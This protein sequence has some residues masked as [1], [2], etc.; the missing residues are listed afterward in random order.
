MSEKVV[1]LGTRG[2]ALALAQSG[3]VARMLENAAASQGLGWR[4]ELVTVQTQGD[5]SRAALSQLGGIGVF[6]AQLRTHL[7]EGQVDLA[8]HSF[9][10]L[11]TAP[12]AGLRIAATPRRADPRDALVASNGMSLAQLP[13]GASVGTGSP[14]RV[15][16]LKALRPDIKTVDLRG[17]VP[18]RLGRVRGVQVAAD[19]GTSPQALG[20]GADLDAVV[21]ACAGLERL[22][23][24]EHISEAF[25]PEQMLPAP[26]QGVLAIETAR[27]L[28]PQLEAVIAQVND[29]ASHLAAVAER[30][31][32]ST[33]QAGCAAPVGTY[34][35]LV[36]AGF[37]YEL[38]L[39]AGVFALDGAA[40]VRSRQAVTLGGVDLAKACHLQKAAELGQRAAQDLLAQGAGQVADLQAIKE[41]G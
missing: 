24:A 14:R 1:R 40:S 18:T 20:T 2:S 6:A 3:M 13:S 36:H 7:L 17:N 5:T 8:V 26:S 25:N 31:V 39:E 41:R 30:A 33:L 32:M 16:Q 4:V 22:G 35:Y 10:D 29:P 23:L 11:P 9:K 38:H 12:V 21:L 28:D 15:A 27:E 19:A 37:D 34:A